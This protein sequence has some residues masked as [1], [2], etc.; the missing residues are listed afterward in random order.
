MISLPKNP[1]DINEVNN[2]LTEFL[3]FLA[4][5]ESGSGIY[6]FN[7]FPR[8]DLNGELVEANQFEIPDNEDVADYLEALEMLPD[9]GGRTHRQELTYTHGVDKNGVVMPVIFKI[10]ILVY[11]GKYGVTVNRMDF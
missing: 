2:P 10:S 11:Q 4:T 3:D 6:M 9:Q 5:S 8:Y 7:H 1:A